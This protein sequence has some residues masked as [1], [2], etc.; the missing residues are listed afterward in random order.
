VG[1]GAGVDDAERKESCPYRNLNSDPSAVQAVTS[2]YTECRYSLYRSHIVHHSFVTFGTPYVYEE[3]SVLERSG[4]SSL[5][6][7]RNTCIHEQCRNVSNA[8]NQQEGS[9]KWLTLRPRN[10][11]KCIFQIIRCENPNSALRICFLYKF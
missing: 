8:S 3:Y 9:S 4:R 1:P 11:R 5:T 6:F 10:R 7:R 2:R